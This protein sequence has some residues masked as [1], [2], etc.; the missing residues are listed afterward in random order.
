VIRLADGE[1]T[2]RFL[3]S[4]IP[5]TI[6]PGG[7]AG[8]RFALGSFIGKIEMVVFYSLAFILMLVLLRLIFRRVAIADTLFVLLA[9]VVVS[10]GKLWV[11]GL[12]INLV[13]IWLLRRFGWL[14]FLSF[15]FG[16]VL[17]L[18]VPFNSG[19]GYAALWLPQVLI[20]AAV[21]AWATH[22]IVT[23]RT[24]N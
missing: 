12:S 17:W 3:R 13:S 16:S 14:A 23:A 9:S 6:S 22:T 11:F 2:S 24:S 4:W 18:L 19:P 5:Q 7:L 21:A 1:I 20:V 10:G 15:H 8:A